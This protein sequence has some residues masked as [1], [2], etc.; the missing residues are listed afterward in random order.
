MLDEWRKFAISMV[1]KAG[2]IL[3][4]QFEKEKDIVESTAG[5][6]KIRMDW[7]IERALLDM[8]KKRE[9][10]FSVLTE[11][12][13][14]V[15]ESNLTWVMDP[16]DGTVNYTYGIPFFCTSLALMQKETLILGVIYDPMRKELFTA[17]RERGAFLNQH[18]IEVSDR[19]LQEAIMEV[20]HFKRR[21]SRV[22]LQ[23]LISQVKKVRKLGS[24]AL[25]LAYV[26][27]GRLDAYITFLSYPWDIAA[28]MLLVEKAGGR[29][30]D[31]Q[32]KT[33][34]VEKGQF[35]FSNGMIHHE[36]LQKICSI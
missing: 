14:K 3:R 12:R 13:G 31:F 28:G 9:E 29:G 15:G 30:T 10:N 2:N 33:A 17:D 21:K 16:L 23:R 7:K 35:L 22:V 11:E 18:S 24:A 34:Q 26:A 25:S 6:V 27:A 5:D 8:V 20:S 4:K 19:S 36:I 1:L 32:G